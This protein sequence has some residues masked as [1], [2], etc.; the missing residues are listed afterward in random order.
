M[1]A[2]RAAA[3]ECQADASV[4]Y[5]VRSLERAALR[6]LMSAEQVLAVALAERDQSSDPFD[7]TT[8]ARRAID[9]SIAL[10]LPIQLRVAGEGDT[11]MSTIGN[12]AQLD[13]L[14]QS[15]LNNAVQHGDS[16]APIDV[17]FTSS[18]GRLHIEIRNR[19]GQRTRRGLGLGSEIA[20]QLASRLGVALDRVI[21]GDDFVA[22]IELHQRVEQEPAPLELVG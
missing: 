13:A 3:E 6:L 10:G 1:T 7:A 18:T 5:Q 4:L 15:V 9:D 11:W 12:A 16:G 8:T 19:I 17:T 22:R 20:A 14:I 21:D 2:A